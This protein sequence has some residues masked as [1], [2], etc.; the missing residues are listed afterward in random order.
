MTNQMKK[1]ILSVSLYNAIVWVDFFM[2]HLNPMCVF[3][4]VYKYVHIYIYINAR[5][6]WGF[7]RSFLL[8]VCHFMLDYHSQCRMTGKNK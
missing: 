5:V 2:I 3:S 1:L 6:S 8:R 7:L 4:F